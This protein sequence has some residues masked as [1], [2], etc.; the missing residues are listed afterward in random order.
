MGSHNPPPLGGQR[1]HPVTDS[2][3]ICNGLSPPL[4]DIVLFGFSLP[5]FPFGL[6]LKV[7]KTHLLGR[8][9]HTLVRKASFPSP[10]DVGFHKKSLITST[11]EKKC[12]MTDH[13]RV[14]SNILRILF[15]RF[16]LIKHLSQWGKC[17]LSVFSYE[18]FKCFEQF[19]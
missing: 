3:T 2:D 1:P 15:F 19:F 14:W 11:F 13:I 9:F 7:F 17:T 4:V 12:L 10:T 16:F 6:A 8:G 5:P 18:S